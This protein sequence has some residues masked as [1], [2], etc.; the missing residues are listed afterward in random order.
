MH[1]LV[2]ISE[3]PEIDRWIISKL[4]SLIKNVDG[5][6]EDYEPTKAGRAIQDFVNDE[7]SNWYV[8][9]CRRRFWKGEYSQDKSAAYQT[10]YKCLDVVAQLSS[11][12]A[13]FYIDQLYSDLVAVSGKGNKTSVH[14]S[15]FPIA[16]E[17]VIDTDLV[18]SGINSNTLNA[19]GQLR[20]L[21]EL[22]P[23]EPKPEPDSDTITKKDFKAAI[24]Y[25]VAHIKYA[26]FPHCTREPKWG[27]YFE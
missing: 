6:Y 4:N 27:D 8:R 3:R 12:I 17:N 1:V 20:T 26:D 22:L 15:D 24:H 14:L 9:L 19:V 11:S 5:F 2:E 21:L 10:L 23:S 16:N 18:Q 13:P 7:L 25:I